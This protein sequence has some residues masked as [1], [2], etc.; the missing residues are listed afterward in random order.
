MVHIVLLAFNESVTLPI[1]STA[2]DTVFALS[3]YQID[4]YQEFFQ[5]SGNNFLLKCGIID[6]GL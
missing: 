4:L 5:S 6:I 3:I 2:A 1:K